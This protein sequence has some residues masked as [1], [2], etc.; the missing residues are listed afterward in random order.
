MRS[1]IG[2]EDIKADYDVL[3]AVVAR[4]QRHSYDALTNPERI[5]LLEVLEHQ[6]RRLQVPGH[7]LINQI[8]QDAT[9][10]EIGG[11]LAHVL[12]DRLLITRAEA[13]RR[14]D[15][16]RDLGVRRTLTGEPLPPRYAATAAAQRDGRIG[17]SHVA[18][19]RRFF[20]QL[21]CWVD[22][23][24]RDAAEADLARWAGEH[25]PESLRKVA[26]RIACYLN[27]DGVFH[28]EDRLRHRGL[29]LGAQQP[30]GMSQ[31]RGWLTPEARATV[32]AVLAKL[33][34]P[35]MCNPD[36]P[37]PVVDGQPGQEAI[38]RDSRS[39]AQR[40]HDGLNAA[41]RALL[42]GGKLGQHNGLPAS[43]IV[44]TTLRDLE[45]AA[46]KG[47]TGGGTLLP[48]SDVIRLARHAHH[49]LA[50]FDNGNPLALYHTKRLASPGQRII[51]YAKDRGCSHPGCDVSGYY[52]EVHHV[53]GYAKCGRTDIDQLTFACG[54]HHP[55]AEQGWITRKNGRG[56]TEWIPPP[57][58]DHGRPRT[59]AFHHPEKLVA[60]GD[61][62]TGDDT[63]DAPDD[64]QPPIP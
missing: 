49:Y 20:D 55:L 47:L 29:T 9:P 51:L 14:I 1:I 39:A 21:P 24:T 42:A 48:M 3:R 12:A 18:V 36:D 43:I 57:H 30:D 33:A 32:E 2:R 17:A 41:L 44:T 37:A 27:P 16:A 46:G 53:T 25:R 6:T 34:A 10:A 61:N 54:G 7:Q 15:D 58:L 52:C 31:L 56:E 4:I 40:N 5:R 59:N 60:D 23:P 19:I 13:A 62:D 50:V 63:S 28:D 35:G 26:D 11:K 45:S 8:E 22:A 64:P 38:Q